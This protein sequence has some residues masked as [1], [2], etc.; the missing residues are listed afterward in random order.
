MKESLDQCTRNN[1]KFALV[2]I[3]S[4]DLRGGGRGRWGLGSVKLK[5]LVRWKLATNAVQ[6]ELITSV[7]KHLGGILASSGWDFL[8]RLFF[9]FNFLTILTSFWKLVALVCIQPW[10]GFAGL[11]RKV[12]CYIS[13]LPTRKIGTHC[14]DVGSAP[15]NNVVQAGLVFDELLRYLPSI[16]RSRCL[17]NTEISQ[18]FKI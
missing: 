10:T 3:L 11:R 6:L 9:L 8:A 16:S 17:I 12:F 7:I 18:K 1:R 14:V 2:H 15:K 5:A 13:C 4:R